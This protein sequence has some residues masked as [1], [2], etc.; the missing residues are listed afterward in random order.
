MSERVEAS[1][2]DLVER[3]RKLIWGYG[4]IFSGMFMLW[5]L[6]NVALSVLDANYEDFARPVAIGAYGAIHY[7]LNGSFRAG[8]RW[9]WI[10]LIAIYSLWLVICALNLV[11]WT[12]NSGSF[13]AAILYG[14]TS[15]GALALLL[16]GDMKLTLSRSA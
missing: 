13:S 16:S 9:G 1:A 15:L 6:A 12:D 2:I 8:K 4:A 3:K 5:A 10:G 11:Y 7:Y 14:L